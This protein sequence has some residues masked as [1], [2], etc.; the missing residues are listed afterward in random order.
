LE[1]VVQANLKERKGE[2]PK[3]RN[4]V[5]ETVN[6]FLLWLGG[7]EALPLILSLQNKAESV[8]LAETKRALSKFNGLS[9][10]DINTIEEMGRRLVAKLLAEPLAAIRYFA[11]RNDA[12]YRLQIAR[13][14]LGL[15][16]EESPAAETRTKQQPPESTE[17]TPTAIQGKI[18]EDDHS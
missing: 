11:S 18:N 7:R 6:Q 16:D 4:I 15:E 13:Q 12:P 9:E 1:K 14:L 5:S 2:I 10:A 8:R 3:V 17:E